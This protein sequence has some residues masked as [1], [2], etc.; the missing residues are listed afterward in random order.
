[1]N[2]SPWLL[3]VLLAGL[4]PLLL[5]TSRAQSPQEHRFTPGDTVVVKVYEEAELDTS[6]VVGR[7]GRIPLQLAGD[8]HIQGMTSAEAAKAIEAAY[9][10]GYLV[11]PRV[12]VTI[13]AVARKR[14][15]IQGQVTK[16]GPYFFPEGEQVTLLQAI[17][18]AG[19]FTRIASPAK[20]TVVR[21]GQT[22]KVDA[23]KM[24]KEGGTPFYLQPGD[25]VNVPESW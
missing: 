6:A 21:G 17:G 23:K 9:R 25:A 3:R 14:F 11:K 16:P 10:D 19:G 15:S 13:G 7:D 12:T 24:Q 22:L 2:K 5:L 18:F 8:V 1:M 20:I 4:L